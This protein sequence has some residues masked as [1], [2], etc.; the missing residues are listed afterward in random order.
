VETRVWD[1]LN[2]LYKYFKET[3]SDGLSSSKDVGK[4]NV[5]SVDK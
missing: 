1:A 3:T 2:D 5:T 4:N